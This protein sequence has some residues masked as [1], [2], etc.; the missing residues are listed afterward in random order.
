ME[1]KKVVEIP[2]GDWQF[3]SK[4]V[5]INIRQATVEEEISHQNNLIEISKRE[6]NTLDLYQSNLDYLVM[7]GGD[8]S[9]LKNTSRHGFVMI[10]ETVMGDGKKN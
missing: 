9:A 1:N 2:D 3:K 10:L 8:E 5:L 4:G 6:D 7:L